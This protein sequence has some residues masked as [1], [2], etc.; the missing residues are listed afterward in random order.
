MY[1]TGK[2]KLTDILAEHP[3]LEQE[4]PKQDPIF[5]K[6]NNPAARL[7]LKHMTVQDASRASGLSVDYLLEE[8]NKVIARHDREDL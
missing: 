7:L 3:W 6:L 4:L 5:E 2:T 8:L 1:Y